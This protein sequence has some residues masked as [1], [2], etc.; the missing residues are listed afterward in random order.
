[1]GSS[2]L[3]SERN[4]VELTFVKEEIPK[5]VRTGGSGR[6]AEPWETHLAP[7]K[8]QAGQSF[9]VW[10]YDKRSGAQGRVTTVRDRLTKVT[11]QDNWTIKVRP[12]GEQFGVYVQYNGTFTPEQMAENA[13]KRQERSERT[14]ASRPASGEVAPTTGGGKTAKERV[15]DA[16]KKAS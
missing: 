6:E 15:A 11:P 14:K 10:T 16:H 9:R 5:I 7:I 1:M 12:V 13:K 3:I 2:P 8:E 4:T